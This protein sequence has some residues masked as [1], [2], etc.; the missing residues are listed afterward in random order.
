MMEDV[1]DELPE[2]VGGRLALDFVNTVDPRHAPD[3]RD[4]LTTYEALLAWAHDAIPELPTGITTL[5]RMSTADPVAA[6]NALEGAI[7]L[8]EALYR[9]LTAAAADR[10]VAD[11]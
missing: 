4:Y 11:G 9:L 7:A 10:R 8:R 5:R 2:R 1:T 3:R 6:T